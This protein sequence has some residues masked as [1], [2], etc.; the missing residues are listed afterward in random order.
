MPKL[1]ILVPTYNRAQLLA[2]TLESILSTQVDC[3]VL[4]RD[5]ASTDNTTE[6][7]ERFMACDPRL[8][9][10][11]NPV[12]QGGNNQFNLLTQDAC[13]EYLTVLP[14]DDLSMPGNYDKKVAILEA[15]PEVGFV[16]SF[17]GIRNLE[18]GE[19]SYPR[20]IE[21]L[22][23]SYIG[24]R[25]EF[26]DLLPGNYI[27]GNT[28]VWRKSLTD[29]LGGLD[30]AMGNTLSDWDLWL[31]YSQRMQTAYL[32]EPLIMGGFHTN[33]QSSNVVVT[34]LSMLLVWRKWLLDAGEPIVLDP[35]MWQRMRDMFL[36]CLR[37]AFREDAATIEHWM[38][39][40]ARMERQYLTRISQRFWQAARLLPSALQAGEGEPD[41]D[42]LVVCGPIRGIGAHGADIRSLVRAL[43]DAGVDARVENTFQGGM[44]ADLPPDDGAAWR[45]LPSG[46]RF[47]QLW[48]LPP[49]QI[50]P[51]EAARAFAIRCAAAT[52]R[53]PEEWV[54][55]CG[56][57]EQLWVP[58]EATA[59]ACISS[60]IAPDRIRVLP[61][62]VD[63]QRYAPD[64]PI[65]R[66]NGS[67]GFNFLMSGPWSHR[68]GW[69]LAIRAYV[70]EFRADEEVALLLVAY[71]P[72][73]ETPEQLGAAITNLAK[74]ASPTGNIPSI[75]LNFG[76]YTEDGMAAIY[77]G[78]Q[79]C[80]QPGRGPAWSRCVLE[81]MACQRP[82]L[83]TRWG[84][85]L[86]F[87]TESNSYPLDADSMQVG[88]PALLETPSLKGHVWAQ[89]STSHL[90][91][92]MREVFTNRAEAAQRAKQAR[93]DVLARN[94]PGVVGARLRDLVAGLSREL[95][96]V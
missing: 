89:P 22:L 56:Q 25:N 38:H 82:V 37:D 33:R 11:R 67:R 4:I 94:A 23:Y 29:E 13:G 19:V 18:T 91:A 30:S 34:T 41:R 9:Y 10:F 31:R 62:C 57:A 24:G 69:D 46:R 36:L 81:A 84:A 86:D 92:L 73:G 45:S 47:T 77:R 58:S 83:A 16:Y 78:A 96:P 90:R 40:F 87:L 7:V 6:V 21:H 93:V 27:P 43:A 66:L 70:E 20:R 39:D 52:D 75:V 49:D 15:H 59:Q 79:A 12:N 54:E 53:L 44:Y 5:D 48:A 26:L 35:R 65:A 60:G 88:A 64:G 1:S 63:A 74:A 95:A 71:S 28:V 61:P 32:N 55:R 80:V 8:R 2:Q 42:A 72:S 3:E 14:D 50:V 76:L 68:K 85:N 51:D 17:R